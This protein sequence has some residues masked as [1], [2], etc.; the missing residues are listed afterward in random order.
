MGAVLTKVN[1]KKGKSARH[2]ATQTFCFLLTQFDPLNKIKATNNF[3]NSYLPSV[4]KK[5]AITED[6]QERS[7]NNPCFHCY[8]FLY[9]SFCP[10]VNC[11]VCFI[12]ETEL[13][14]QITSSLT[15]Y[16]SVRALATD[17]LCSLCKNISFNDSEGNLEVQEQL[18]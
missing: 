9:L 16:V 7:K 12:T 4:G 14:A 18:H 11:S 15:F 10:N 1:Q 6:I 13:Q 17:P 8:I 3:L 2:R 5:L